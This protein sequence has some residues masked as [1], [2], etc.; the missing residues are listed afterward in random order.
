[1][2][3]SDVA[4]GLQ[5][6]HCNDLV[7]GDI[8]PHNVLV[9][10]SGQEFLFKITDY[11]CYKYKNANQFSS[12]SSSLKQLMTP[13]Y[14]APELISDVGNYLD[15]TKVS[16]NY[17][18][19]VLSYE[20]A[21]TREPW[22]NVSM[23][24]IDSVRKGYR[25][26]IPGNASKFVSSLI[27]DCWKHDSAARPSALQVSQL[28]QDYLELSSTPE[29]F[30]T[31]TSAKTGNHQN[32]LTCIS[33]SITVGHARS[34]NVTSTS[35]CKDTITSELCLDHSVPA[36]ITGSQVV[37]VLS[38]DSDCA[39]LDEPNSFNATQG[40]EVPQESHDV[41][42][43]NLDNPSNCTPTT[44]HTCLPGPAEGT[45]SLESSMMQDLTDV[46]ASITK[47]GSCSSNPSI[48]AS[49]IHRSKVIQDLANASTVSQG[50][51]PLSSK[52]LLSD[53]M[54]KVKTTLNVRELK[55][56]QVQCINAVQ[57]GS[58][59]ILVQP[60]GSGKSLCFTFPALLNPGKV[61]IVIE[62]VVAIIN[63]Q[64]EALQ[65]KE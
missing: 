45:M 26:V 59:V 42:V 32:I 8:K 10:G 5:Y 63:N 28:L 54:E 9:T 1:M 24:L 16:D 20:V 46:C 37:D 56:F 53:N 39:S 12:R 40:C 48:M 6:L 25:P 31:N 58:D 29:V 2:A 15:P 7:H 13:G 14:L 27:Q 11:A 47:Q 64:V 23:Q 21:F 65:K 51:D 35:M 18:F 44:S 41:N 30:V 43:D 17:S 50:N 57:Q 34:N 60:T 38:V 36:K 3:L 4:E 62:P 49:Q 19:S 33:G 52:D 55:E 61:S 22:P